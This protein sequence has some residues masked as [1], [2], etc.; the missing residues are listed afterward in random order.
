M[1]KILLMVF[2]ILMQCSYASFFGLFGGGGSHHHRTD[3]NKAPTQIDPSIQNYQQW[4][5]LAHTSYGFQ[6]S[7]N[8]PPVTAAF[9]ADASA[10][11]SCKQRYN[12]INQ[13]F[14]NIISLSNNFIA[15]LK[16]CS[17]QVFGPYQIQTINV[18]QESN[19]TLLQ[20]N[21]LSTFYDVVC[22]GMGSYESTAYIRQQESINLLASQNTQQ[23]LDHIPTQQVHNF[24]FLFYI[25]I[26]LALISLGLI[27]YKYYKA[28]YTK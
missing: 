3:V 25:C 4:C 14:P 22:S 9:K 10:T 19:N 1:R 17:G 13:Q 11:V 18:A 20:S 15:S 23:C 21:T 24:L 8:Q 16:L 27:A 28:N 5:T 2:V 7:C 6:I 26:F 12:G